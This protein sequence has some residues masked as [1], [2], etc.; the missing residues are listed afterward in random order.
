MTHSGGKP[1]AVGDRGQRYEVSCFDETKNARIVIGWTDDAAGAARWATSVELRP[2]WK[3][4]W[5]TDR[6]PGSTDKVA[7]S[8]KLS[9]TGH[10]DAQDQIA[11]AVHAIQVICGEFGYDPCEW[12]NDQTAI[13]DDLAAKMRMVQGAT[14]C[15][16]GFIRDCVWGDCHS[17]TKGAATP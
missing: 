5:V 1:H 15:P 12:L 9:A 17:R 4:A 11:K 14:T 6:R 10:S 7:A 16:H 8:D 3:F 2:S 13:T